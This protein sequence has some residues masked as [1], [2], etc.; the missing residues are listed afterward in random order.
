MINL[1]FLMMTVA[2]IMSACLNE[3]ATRAREAHE[4]SANNTYGNGTNYT[5]F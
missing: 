2:L 5:L 1:T 4:Y 3:I